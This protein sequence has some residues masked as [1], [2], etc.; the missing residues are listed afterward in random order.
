MLTRPGSVVAMSW[1]PALSASRA[2][3]YQR[4]PLQYRLHVVDRIREPPSQAKA[5]GTL[6]HAVLQHIFDVPA[7]ERNAQAAVDMLP[8]QW[9]RLRA[10]EPDV[11]GLFSDAAELEAWK[12]RA[13]ELIRA[14]FHV[15]DP[16]HLEP[17]GRER[18]VEA[19]VADG[20][21]VR[22]FVD[23]IDRAP[24]T[25][26]LR[27]IDYKTGRAPGP[28][29]RGEALYQMRF[30]AMLL[31][32]SARLPAR[33]QLLYL[34][35]GATLTL[36]PDPADIGAFEDEVGELWA[37]IETDARRGTFEPRRG[38]LCPWCGVQ[39]YCP[40]FEGATPDLPQEGVERLLRTRV[41]DATDAPRTQAPAARG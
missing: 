26:A 32:R 16:R 36:D 25:G 31:A 1:Q 4:C 14:Y 7:A 9:E 10:R 2:K 17:V 28:A 21:R 8:E 38:P 40:L 23:R 15:E 34:K 13:R 35:S 37:R 12:E 29:Y 6:V 19:V 18:R 22:G 5:L 41:T 3:E 33:T 24:H 20:V 30:Y 39:R 11:D 27:V